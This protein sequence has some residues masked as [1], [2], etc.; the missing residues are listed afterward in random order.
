M[1]LPILIKNHLPRISIDIPGP[2]RRDTRSGSV[3]F[4]FPRIWIQCRDETH[5]AASHVSGQLSPRLV[6][7]IALGIIE[8]VW[9]LISM[10]SSKMP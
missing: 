6:R 1:T 10:L 7:N 5:P 8:Y 4:I 3:R 2:R 9:Q